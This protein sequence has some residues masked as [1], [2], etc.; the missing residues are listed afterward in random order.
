MTSF[1]LGL[2]IVVAATQ[3]PGSTLAA[4]ASAG[5]APAAVR[6]DGLPETAVGARSFDKL[7]TVSEGDVRKAQALLRAELASQQPAIEDHSR[8]VCGMRV[9]QADPQIDPKMIRR[10]MV[11]PPADSTTTFHIKRI[12]PPTCAE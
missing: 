7:F 12:P 11:D 10:P 2:L 1:P 4:P 3:V 8:Y 9:I 6:I 5:T